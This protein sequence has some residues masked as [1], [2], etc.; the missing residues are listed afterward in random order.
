VGLFYLLPRHAPA[1]SRGTDRPTCLLAGWLPKQ[2]PV[3]REQG[4]RREQIQQ[5]CPVHQRGSREGLAQEAG[6]DDEGGERQGEGQDQRRS[7]G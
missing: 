1:S 7:G 6:L 5:V 3:Q 2:H 4:K